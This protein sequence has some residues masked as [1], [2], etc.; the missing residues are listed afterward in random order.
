MY[1]KNFIIFLLITFTY[2]NCYG[3]N[4]SFFGLKAG[5][6]IS[7]IP[8]KYKESEISPS[9]PTQKY[10]YTRKEYPLLGPVIGLEFYSQISDHFYFLLGIEYQMTGTRYSGTNTDSSSSGINSFYENKI[11][12]KI[13]LPVAPGY[14]FKI[15]NNEWSILIG[16]RPNFLISG[17]YY[18]KWIEEGIGTKAVVITEYNPF[19]PEFSI[20]PLKRFVSQVSII[21]SNNIS[22]HLKIDLSLNLSKSLKVYQEYDYLEYYLGEYKNNDFSLSLTYLFRKT[23][24]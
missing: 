7:K 2:V 11:L 6:S 14:K 23:N 13:C 19:K 22:E 16:Y 12:H 17:K 5:F 8:K 1:L 20:T 4:K 9:R 3:Q 15:K 10:E 18:H 21:I 24:K